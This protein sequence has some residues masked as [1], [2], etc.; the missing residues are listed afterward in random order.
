MLVLLV[1]SFR[2]DFSVLVVA[3]DESFDVSVS[4]VVFRFDS[5]VFVVFLDYTFATVVH[6][7]GFALEVAVFVEFLFGAILLVLDVGGLDSNFTARV[8]L[9]ANIFAG[10]EEQCGC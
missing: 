2:G 10:G 3:G 9:G 1:L 7:V 8:F 5:S 4:V 6:V